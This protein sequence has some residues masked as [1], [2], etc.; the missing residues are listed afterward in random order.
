MTLKIHVNKFLNYYM[1]ATSYTADSD[2]NALFFFQQD[3]TQK[4]R[5]M[6]SEILTVVL[7]KI[8]VSWVVTFCCWVGSSQ[9]FEQL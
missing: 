2:R 3:V 6:R 5:F 4:I 1:R 9:Q 7:L 8:Q